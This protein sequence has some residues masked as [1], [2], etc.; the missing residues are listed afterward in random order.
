M[1]HPKSIILGGS[2]SEEY[3]F[4]RNEMEGKAETWATNS[5]SA[6][7]NQR[8]PVISKGWSVNEQPYLRLRNHVFA[9][10]EGKND[11]TGCNGLFM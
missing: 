3:C 5:R 8:Y 10:M 4:S 7:P 6:E 2:R 9:G 11:L 1:C